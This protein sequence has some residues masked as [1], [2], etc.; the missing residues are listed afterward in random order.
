MASALDTATVTVHIE[1]DTD[2]PTHHDTDILAT[3]VNAA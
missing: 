1:F 3:S 2:T